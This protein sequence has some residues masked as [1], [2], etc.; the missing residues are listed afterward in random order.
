V[1]Q[2]KGIRPKAC[3]LSGC[4]TGLCDS[5]KRTLDAEPSGRSACEAGA[6]IVTVVVLYPGAAAGSA[7]IQADKEA[8]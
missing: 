4:K 3:I 6:K 1:H 8:Y 5:G 2:A 7:S